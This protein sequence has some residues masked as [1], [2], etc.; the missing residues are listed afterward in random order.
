MSDNYEITKQLAIIGKVYPHFSTVINLALEE[1]QSLRTEV[2]NKQ[3]RIQVLEVE[4]E[5]WI[6]TSENTVNR[7]NKSINDKLKAILAE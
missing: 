7:L 2:H 1:I 6:K 4:L 5:N 3:N